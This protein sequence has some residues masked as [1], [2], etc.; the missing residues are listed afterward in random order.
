MTGQQSTLIIGL[1]SDFGDDRLGWIVAE[2][3]AKR[4]PSCA[5]AGVRSPA[6]LLDRLESVNRLHIIDACRGAGPAGTIVR[7][8][9]PIEHRDEFQFSG[10]HDL[11]LAASL[12]LAE[13]LGLLP[14][15]VTIWGVDLANHLNC[16]P[17]TYR[18][19]LTPEI[20]AT[21]PHLI[22]RIVAEVTAEDVNP[23]EL[24]LHHA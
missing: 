2:Q 6:E 8:D 21:L 16:L 20:D 12:E 4:L 9:W 14:P 10:T 1:G 13:R 17:E 3:L 24:P 18:A 7:F 5:V 22:T 19:E 15:R 11:G 23:A